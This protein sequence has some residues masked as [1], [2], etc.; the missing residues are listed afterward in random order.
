MTTPVLDAILIARQSVDDALRPLVAAKQNDGK[1]V[2][3]YWQRQSVNLYPC[4][5]HQS[6]DRGGQDASFLAIGG[7][8]GLWAVQTY[9]MDQAT[10]D[11]WLAAIRDGMDD[12]ALP[13][14]YTGYS[15]QADFEQ[16]LVV[17]PD[18]SIWQAGAIWR[19]RIT[20]T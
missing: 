2:R 20:R 6:Q 16:P 1:A 12:L 11:D 15:I 5:I 13:S 19:I 14:G 9:A 8:S 18:E 7:W 17:P 10:A 4:V 3:L